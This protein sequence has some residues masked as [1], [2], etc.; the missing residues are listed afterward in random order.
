MGGR[1][2]ALKKVAPTQR[3]FF[4]HIPVYIVYSLCII[5]SLY[6]VYFYSVTFVKNIYFCI[7]YYIKLART[8]PASYSLMKSILCVQLEATTSQRVP[9]VLKPSFQ[10]KCRALV[11]TWTTFQFW[12]QPIFHG[13]WMQLSGEDS[14]S[15]STFRFL[16]LVPAKPCSK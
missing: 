7:F 3:F 9:V 15:V 4:Q 1:G 16:R 12:V 8:N 10:F 13:P 2:W 6:I 5:Y 14:R 11:M